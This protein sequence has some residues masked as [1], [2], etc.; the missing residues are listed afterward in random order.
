[1]KTSWTALLPKTKLG[2]MR[3]RMVRFAPI[4]E[5]ILLLLNAKQYAI[6]CQQQRHCRGPVADD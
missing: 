2:Q 1:M 3:P 4:P 6:T 5:L